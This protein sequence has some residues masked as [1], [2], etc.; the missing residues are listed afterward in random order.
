MLKDRMGGTRDVVEKREEACRMV[1]SPP[2]V[3]IRSTLEWRREG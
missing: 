1:P 2:R 3:V